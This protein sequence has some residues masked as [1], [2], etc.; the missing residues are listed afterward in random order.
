MIKR[1]NFLMFIVMFIFTFIGMNGVNAAKGLYCIYDDAS[2]NDYHMLVQDVGGNYSVYKRDSKGVID[3]YISYDTFGWTLLGTNDS[4]FTYENGTLGNLEKCPKY[5]HG[6][7]EFRDEKGKAELKKD[8]SFSDSSIKSDSFSFAS[9]V[10]DSSYIINSDSFTKDNYKTGWLVQ[11]ESDG[12]TQSCLYTQFKQK[13]QHDNDSWYGTIQLD[14]NF[15]QKKVRV[16]GAFGNDDGVFS[17]INGFY[18]NA[19][20]SYITKYF[21]NSCPI[22]YYVYFKLKTGDQYLYFSDKNL[23]KGLDLDGYTL[24]DFV[25]SNSSP[26]IKNNS[27]IVITPNTI[28]IENCED[29]FGTDLLK[30]LHDGVNAVKIM[31][32]LLLIGLGI[33]DFAK[34]VFGGSEDN[35]KKSAVKFGKR[36]LIGVV[37]FFI[38]SILNIV[39]EI[40]NKI[41]GNIDSSLCG[42]L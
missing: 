41:W 4:L 2:G 10:D 30:I 5:W 32:P 11:P 24:F 31:I 18:S 28:T 12:Y 9:L 40:A 36:V 25:L 33:L 39:L 27:S 7:G 20:F 42:I 19:T 17:K 21:N 26:K 23:G 3:S 6:D 29:V 37:I 1:R 22:D 8:F 38:P 14:I 16:S 13:Q 34:A 15:N 35:M